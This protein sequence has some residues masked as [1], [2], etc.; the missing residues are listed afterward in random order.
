MTN[1][2]KRRRR[3]IIF[4]IETNISKNFE[5]LKLIPEIQYSL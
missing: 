5:P 2:R 4:D 3:Y 1:R